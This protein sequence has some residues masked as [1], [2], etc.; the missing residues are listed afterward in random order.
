MYAMK[1]MRKSA[2]VQCPEHVF[3]EQ[4][5]TRNT[6]HM[7]CIRCGLLPRGLHAVHVEGECGAD[8]HPR[9]SCTFQCKYLHGLQLSR[10]SKLHCI[11]A[12]GRHTPSGAPLLPSSQLFFCAK[13]LGLTLLPRS[14]EGL[15]TTVHIPG[16]PLHG[17]HESVGPSRLPGSQSW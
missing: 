7:F 4:A 12:T 5:I 8:A 14:A 10:V 3:C 2:V 1:R 11:P 13:S 15:C 17:L 9:R 6:A 16:N